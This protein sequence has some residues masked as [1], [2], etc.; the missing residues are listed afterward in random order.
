MTTF[1]RQPA[2]AGL[3]YPDIRSV[4]N[5]DLEDLLDQAKSHSLGGRLCGLISPHAGYMYSGLTAATGYKTVMGN[6]FDTIVVVGPSHR[7]YFDGISIYPGDGYETPLGTVL[8]NDEMRSQLVSFHKKITLSTIGH[9]AE[10]SVEVQLPFLQKVIERFS[11][12]PI[13][14]GDQRRDYCM[15]LGDALAKACAGRNVLLVASS[16]LSHYHTSKTAERLD[17][18]VIE[19]VERYDAPAL[20]EMLEMEKVEACGGGPIVAVMNAARA[21]GARRSRILSYSNSGDI[22]GDRSAVV[23]YLSAAFIQET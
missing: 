9:R 16:D 10:H 2:V 19:E 5:R 23:G 17:R 7:E 4:L 12:V 14:M 1:V 13:V 22:T 11:F 18:L 15:L 6:S 20:M 8:M 21:M 3:F